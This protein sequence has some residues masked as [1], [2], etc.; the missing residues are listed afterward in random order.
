MNKAVSVQNTDANNEVNKT[1][2]NNRERLIKGFFI[3]LAVLA[4]VAFW[5][6]FVYSMV[7][8]NEQLALIFGTIIGIAIAIFVP[9]QILYTLYKKFTR[10]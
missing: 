1:R 3:A 7:T 5:G 10:S 8:G 9:F 4:M 6:T 2:E